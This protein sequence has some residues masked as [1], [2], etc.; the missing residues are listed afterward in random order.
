MALLT[1]Q[2][3]QAGNCYDIFA[4]GESHNFIISY[5]VGFYVGCCSRELMG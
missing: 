3:G 2:K 5:G 4:T 1:K